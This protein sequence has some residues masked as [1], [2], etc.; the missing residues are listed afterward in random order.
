[1]KEIKLKRINRKKY[2]TE[3]KEI[4][5]IRMEGLVGRCPNSN[6]NK[7]LYIIDNRK[8]EDGKK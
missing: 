8:K 4:V 1:M 2:C 6:C 3:C 7:V 5:E